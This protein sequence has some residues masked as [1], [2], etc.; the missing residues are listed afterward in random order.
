MIE[1]FKA[2][3]YFFTT[4]EFFADKTAYVM[5][6]MA[7]N[8]HNIVLQSTCARLTVYLLKYVSKS[9]FEDIISYYD[10]DI[11]N[12]TNF[13][14]RRLF[15]P[16]FEESLLHFSI[17]FSKNVFFMNAFIIM[18]NNCKTICLAKLIKL[19]P[20]LYP[21]ICTDK[22]KKLKIAILTRIDNIKKNKCKDKETLSV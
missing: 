12:T 6:S 16:I 14:E 19:L 8:V 21:L 17:E 2:S 3:R 15:I 11:V 4:D 13:Y 20:S 18:F 9:C 1:T 22:D 10:K 7:K 5:M